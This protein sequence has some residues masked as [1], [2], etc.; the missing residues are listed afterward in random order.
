M[1]LF[2]I[3][4][5]DPKPPFIARMLKKLI[6][7][8]VKVEARVEISALDTPERGNAE[9]LHVADDLWSFKI[10]DIIDHDGTL[11][12][13]TVDIQADDDDE[14]KLERRGNGYL[15]RYKNPRKYISV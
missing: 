9:V 10:R 5:D 7:K 11:E 14:L 8:G 13:L 2:E 12:P 4:G 1:K 3:G 6:E 15:L